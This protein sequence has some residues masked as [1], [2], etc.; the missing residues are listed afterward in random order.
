MNICGCLVHLAP[1]FRDSA[2]DAIAGHPGV[3]IHAETE[4]GRFVVTVEDTDTARASETIMALHQVPGVV[5]LSLT[6]H[7]FEDLSEPQSEL[8]PELTA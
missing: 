6:Y 2:R 1:A 3:E 4:D 5:S 7:S 8:E